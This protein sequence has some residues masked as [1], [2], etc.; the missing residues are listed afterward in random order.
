MSEQYGELLGDSS[1]GPRV[2]EALGADGHRRRAGGEQVG[3]VGTG[4]DP[5][6][7]DHGHPH[8]PGD[9]GHLSKGHRTDGRSREAAR[10]A[11]EP[12]AA[13]AGIEGRT[14]EG[15]Y[16]RDRVSPGI[17]RRGRHRRGLGGGRAQL[18]DEGKVGEGTHVLDRPGRLA[19]VGAHL[20]A[21]LHVRAGEVELDERYLGPRAHL[22]D[23]LAELGAVEAHHRDDERHREPCENRQVLGQEAR[24]ALVR[25]SDRVEQA[26]RGLPETRRGVARAGSEGE[27]FRDERVKGKP[28][29]ELVAEGTPGGDR[30]EGA[31]AVEDR[32]GQA[33]AAEVDGRKAGGQAAVLGGTLRRPAE[34]WARPRRQCTAPSK[35]A[36]S[37]RAASSTGP[38]RH[39]RTKPSRVG[40]AQP[41]QAP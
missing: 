3:R 6:H 11:A 12:R 14:P 28:L 40:T 7:A 41:K 16:E 2:A 18:D 17:L 31:G 30:V 22:G 13:G 10:P 19:R 38:S 25:K 26:G 36:V 21:G 34:G 9:G 8:A 24:E 15:V 29:D 35:S 4:C 1:A 5:A 32:P 20:E 23:E 37:S 39:R 33:D 27:G